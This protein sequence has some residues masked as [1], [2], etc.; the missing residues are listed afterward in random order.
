VVRETKLLYFWDEVYPEIEAYCNRKIQAGDIDDVLQEIFIVIYKKFDR[1]MKSG[2]GREKTVTDF[3]LWAYRIASNKIS[4]LARRNNRRTHLDIDEFLH[5]IPSKN[6][7]VA[8]VIDRHVFQ[9]FVSA[10]PENDRNVILSVLVDDMRFEDI[11]AQTGENIS[12]VKT[13]FRR[14]KKKLKKFFEEFYF[15]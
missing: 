6:D 14:A 7:V 9:Q 3:K 4:N 5:I 15:E 13:R 2:G 12:T 11:S 8:D 1:F 10:L